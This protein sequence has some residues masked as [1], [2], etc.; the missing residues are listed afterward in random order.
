M[1][2]LLKRIFDIAFSLSAIVLLLPVSAVIAMAIKIT[3]KGPV[4]FKQE[5]AG[6]NAKPF[7]F[8]KFRTMKTGVEPFGPSPKSAHDPRFTKVGRFL[9]EYS[10]D[11]LP[12]LFNILKA[13]MSIVGP[14]PLYTSQMSEWN[15]RQK[16][17]LLV[18]PG[19]TGLAQ[20]SGRG[21]LTRE[22][23]LE[24]DVKYVETASILTDIKIVLA[25]AVQIF[26]RKNI[27]EK[28]YSQTE[29]TRA[30]EQQQAK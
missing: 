28:R 14:R 4:I 22:E 5:R 2:I 27:Y 23:K 19:L 9:R 11:E 13:D 16:K 3:S 18:K 15:E 30:E 1:R 21:K 10:L 24:L 17:R 7:V 26:R 29:Y 12:Q 25:T 6:K 20:I 8:Y